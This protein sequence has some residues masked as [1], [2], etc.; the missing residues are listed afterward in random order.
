MCFGMTFSY[1]VVARLG[2]QANSALALCGLPLFP[3]S[4]LPI[5]RRTD[6]WC[7]IAA[8]CWLQVIKGYEQGKLS[9]HIVGL[10]EGDTLEFKGPVM[11]LT[12]KPN[13][14]K[15]IGMARPSDLQ[16]SF[17]LALC[18]GLLFLRHGCCSSGK[19]YWQTSL[20]QTSLTTLQKILTLLLL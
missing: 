18:V 14:K 8:L 11:K 5:S 20:G 13:M 12:Y 17:K 1:K 2:R 3:M 9:K 19:T 4:L 16:I 10:V 15:A 6:D 7:V